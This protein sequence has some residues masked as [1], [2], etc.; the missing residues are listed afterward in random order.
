MSGFTKFLDRYFIFIM[1]AL[2]CSMVAFFFG[3]NHPVEPLG[4]VITYG[5]PSWGA[6]NISER[7]FLDR[8]KLKAEIANGDPKG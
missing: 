4:K 3:E 5:I 8:T 2:V 7:V 6:L 1:G